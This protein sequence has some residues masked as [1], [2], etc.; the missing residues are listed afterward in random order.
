METSLVDARQA[1]ERHK[2]TAGVRIFGDSSLADKTWGGACSPGASE[3]RA[4]QMEN[5]R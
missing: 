1:Y 3:Y 4:L 5:L 2:L